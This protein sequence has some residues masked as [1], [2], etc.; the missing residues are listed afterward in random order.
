MTYSKEQIT[1]HCKELFLTARQELPSEIAARLTCS[2]AMRNHGNYRTQLLFNTWDRFQSDVLPSQHFCY[3]LGYDPDHLW[4]RYI[5]SRDWY[6]HL[7]I[8]TVRLYR[9]REE[10][11][12][13]LERRLPRLSVAPFKVRILDRAIS[14]EMDFH[15]PKG[16]AH[17]VKFLAPHYTQLIWT[18]HPVLIPIIDRYSCGIG[19]QEVKSEVSRRGRS[20]IRSPGV[21][22]REM[23][24]EYSRS[25]PPSWRPV[26]LASTAFKCALCG[27]SLRNGRHHIDHIIP[28]SRGGKTEFKNLQPL[29]AQCN[30]RKGNREAN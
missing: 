1:P 9:N 10:I 3:C 25:I 5:S 6:L 12:G 7:W 23:V 14:I 26:I 17:L 11:K 19:R 2:R 29:C 13:L 16:P 4:T 15:L 24:R 27:V 8:N 28:F 30:L 22:N 21:A 20:E 18:I